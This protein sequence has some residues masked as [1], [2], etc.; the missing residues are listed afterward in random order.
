[1][2]EKNDAL[3]TLG[4]YL[5]DSIYGLGYDKYSD[6]IGD[7]DDIMYHLINQRKK[8]KSE[9][10]ESNEDRIERER[11]EKVALRNKKID[12]IIG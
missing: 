8:Q 10:Y 6:D 2:R 7:Y 3:S 4:K 11:Q 12:D 5:S 1:M 9:K